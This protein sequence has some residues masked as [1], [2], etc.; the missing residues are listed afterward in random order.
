MD[1][2]ALD[3]PPS[4]L[5]KLLVRWKVIA[6]VI[7]I[8][9]VIAVVSG[10]FLLRNAGQGPAEPEFEQPPSLEELAE[11]YPKL[12]ALLNDPTLGSVYKEFLVAFETGGVDA[13]RELAFQRGLLND[14]DEIRITLLV[15]DAQVVPALT[16]ELEAAGITVEGSYKERINVGVPVALIEQLAEQQGTDALFGQLTQMEHI[17]RLELPAPNRGD[18]VLDDGTQGEGVSVTGASAWHEAGYRGQSVRVGV[19]DLGFD[20]YRSLLGSDLP[21]NVVA[22]SFAYGKEPDESGEVHGTACAEIVHEMAPD[23]ELF[24]AYYDSTLVSMG[25]AVDWLLSQ[26]VQ[27]ITNSTSGVVGPMDG[28]DES[29]AM[30][31]EAVSQG[32]LWVNSS[33]NA[34]EEHYRGQFTDTDGDSLHEFPDGTER[35]GVYFYAPEILIALNWDDWE[36]VT[37]DYDLFL[38]DDQGDLVGSSEDD[39]SGLRGQGASELLVGNEVAEGTYYISIVAHSTT[40]PGMLDVYTLGAAPEFP[41]AD[42]SLGSPADARG[43]LAVGAT[44]V[45]NDR[46]ASYSS[47][48][49]AND[50]RLKPELSAPAGVSSSSYAPQVFNGTSASTPHVAGA[51]ALVW[52]AFPDYSAAQVRDYLQGHALDLG[53]PGPDNGFGHGR[54]QLPSPP[55]VPTEPPPTA[56]PT[57]TTP[58]TEMPEPTEPPPPTKEIAPTQ[59][60]TPTQAPKPTE[61]ARL[62]EPVEEES[63]TGTSS[64]RSLLLVGALGLLGVLVALGGGG[65]LLA[66][67]LRSPRPSPQAAP[68]YPSPATPPGLSAPGQATPVSWTPP[69]PQAEPGGAVLVGAGPRPAPL[70]SGLT[71]IGRSSA[72]DI[73]IDSLLVSRR[74]AQLECSGGGCTVQDLGSANGLFVNGRRI[75]HSVLNPGDRLRIGDVDLTFQPAGASQAPAWLEIGGTRHPLLQDRTDIGRSRSNDIHLADERVSRHHARIELQQD[76]FVISDLDSANGTYVNGQRIERHWLQSGDEIRIGDTRL[77]FH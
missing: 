65:F 58:P 24:F 39:Q 49:P 76:V 70:R 11:L 53:P 26:G 47:Q 18:T 40:R 77:S 15:D 14:R 67:L 41:V 57:V 6:A 12:A 50:G 59:P 60:P 7:A 25:Q 69:P 51:A 17:I 73:I 34:A 21:E 4:F 63:D 44:E 61:V 20:G 22:A 52:S 10:V 28:S 38:Y 46:L 5:D 16:A 74:H 71:T 2:G 3:E 1:T 8:G 56:P 66:A 55:A 42:H 62:P 64:G 35:M 68:A 23:A 43:A 9:L 37:E 30:V 72:N 32:V 48:G 29:A 33:G 36:N 54:L 27:I 19:L 31:D 75:S 45:R 13:A